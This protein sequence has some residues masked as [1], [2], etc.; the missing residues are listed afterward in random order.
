MMSTLK[1]AARPAASILVVALLA[2]CGSPT[3]APTLSVA[4]T[5]TVAIP[6]TAVPT[7]TP[8]AFI[9]GWLQATLSPRPP[10]L[11]PEEQHRLLD[12]LS[13]NGGCDLP[14][15]WGVTPGQTAW[16]DMSAL[17]QSFNRLYENETQDS[18]WPIYTV[19]L[20]VRTPTRGVLFSLQVTVGDGLVQRILTYNEAHDLPSFYSYWSRYSMRAMLQQLGPPDRVYV[21]VV[22]DEYGPSPYYSLLVIDEEDKSAIWLEGDRTR[23]NELCPQFDD[24]DDVT[25]LRIS[26]ANPA[27]SIEILPSA[28]IQETD[29]EFWRPIDQVLGI[30]AHS[31][32]ERMLSETPAC[33][34]LVA[35]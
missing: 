6:P 12:L 8:T 30:D 2:A 5:S 15:F 14:C 7:V 34:A 18:G 10:V 33:F 31:F 16:G 26:L 13:T 1:L 23:E 28:W 35:E 32:Y 17:L 3:P 20:D 22:S 29:S 4:Y 9:P 27:G 11:S 24:G 21:H 19:A 25:N